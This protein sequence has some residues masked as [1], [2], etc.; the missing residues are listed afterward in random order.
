MQ[1]RLRFTDRT[2]ASRAGTIVVG[3]LLIAM[4]FLI[5]TFLDARAGSTVGAVVKWFLVVVLCIGAAARLAYGMCSVEWNITADAIE[6]RTCFVGLP[7]R[8]RSIP[9]SHVQHLWYER[10][11]GRLGRRW[12]AY[13]STKHGTTHGRFHLLDRFENSTPLK[14]M[15]GIREALPHVV[16]REPPWFYREFLANDFFLSEPTPSDEVPPCP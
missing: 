7:V 15:H 11:R 8:T 2:V 3:A 9:A 10:N 5:F 4:A 13:M 14:V 6:R 16:L 12:S 1:N